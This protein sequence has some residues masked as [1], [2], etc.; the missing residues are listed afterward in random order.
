M[1]IA[2][3]EANDGRTVAHK[4]IAPDLAGPITGGTVYNGQLL[5][6][7]LELGLNACRLDADRVRDALLDR[8]PCH[9]WV[10]SLYLDELPAIRSD[11][12]SNHTIGLLAHY[13][14]SL[15]LKGAAVQRE[16]LSP[17]EQRAL[18][19]ADVFLVTSRF[20][21]DTLSKLS[22]TKRPMLVVE[23][24]CVAPRR[25]FRVPG[26]AALSAILIANL[27]P[28]KGIEPFLCELADQLRPSDNFLLKIVGSSD[29]DKPYALACERVAH[30]H[31][32]LS[33]CVVF[34]GARSP[35]A[36]GEEISKSNLLV[37][38]S[39]METFGMALSEARTIG[40]PIL[41]HAGGNVSAHV[42]NKAGG[43]LVESHR[44][45]ARSFLDLCRNRWAL[46]KRLKAASQFKTPQRAWSEAANDYV[47]QI[48]RLERSMRVQVQ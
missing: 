1:S 21:R 46:I 38:A 3:R 9:L 23:P 32:Q 17:E 13:L 12:R 30:A 2:R 35:L 29:L 20:M 48:P 27:T 31:P 37:S 14:P 15:V 5:K 18:D 43:E 8:S 45:L 47:T 33:R 22:N 28:G 10:D 26:G 41:A 34:C 40:V 4:F 19:V 42:E 7:L 39:V 24:G 6:A 44:H 25:G 16:D 36:V 11:C